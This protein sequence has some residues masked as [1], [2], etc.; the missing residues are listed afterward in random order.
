MEP[1]AVD[2]TDCVICPGCI[3]SAGAIVNHAT[4][5]CDGVHADCNAT[6]AETTPVPSGTKVKC[7]E[8]YDR[9]TVD[10]NDLFFNP[11]EWAKRLNEMNIAHI[12]TPIGGKTYSF[13]DV[14]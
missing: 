6:V 3:L 13:D 2:Y 1:M 4:I 11:D 9:K 10:V 8:V 5:C 12:P 7:G 14:M